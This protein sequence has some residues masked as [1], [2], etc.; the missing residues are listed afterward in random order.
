MKHL[1]ESGLNV[2]P[3]LTVRAVASAGLE[4]LLDLR[5]E[6]ESRDESKGTTDT[7]KERYSSDDFIR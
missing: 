1:L 4:K 2:Y 5:N 3:F 7:L 6:L